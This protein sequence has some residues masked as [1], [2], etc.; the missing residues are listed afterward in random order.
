MRITQSMLSQNTLANLNLNLSAVSKLQQ[1]L[2]S[3]KAIN[4]PSDSPTGTNS[5][6]QLR[7]ALAANAQYDRN[8]TDGATWLGS[9]SS[10][11]NT[12]ISQVQ[13]VRDLTV[14]AMN[15]GAMSGGDETDSAA[16]VDQLRKSLL[17]LANSQVN[18]RPLFGGP[19]SGT[20]AYDPV[21]GAYLGRGGTATEPAIPNTR[22]ISAGAAVRVDITGAEAFGDPTQGDDLFAVVNKISADMTGNTSDLGN[23]L[24]A[25]DTAL[26][27]LTNAAADVGAR[28]KRITDAQ[29]V[30]SSITTALTSQLSGVE[31]ADMP[32]T[33]TQLQLQENG[34]QAALAVASQSLQRS[35]VDFLR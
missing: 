5:A 34:Y 3:G 22:R 19:N 11:L 4:L 30:N 26:S 10:T 29:A 14:Q 8:M 7:G 1:Q 25:L 17:G 28:T 35:L 20:Q 23:Q 21:S 32:S 12:M 2:S 33:I 6:M 27:R 18:G 31:D 13:R 16:E 15:T 9:T 24:S